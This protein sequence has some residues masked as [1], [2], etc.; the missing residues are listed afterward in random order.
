MSSAPVQRRRSAVPAYAGSH[1][2]GGAGVRLTPRRE[3]SGKTGRG[4]RQCE[5]P[6]GRPGGP[7]LGLAADRSLPGWQ[8]PRADMPRSPFRSG[9][10]MPVG[11]P[12]R[13]PGRIHGGRLHVDISCS[14]RR[15]GHATASACRSKG[16]GSGGSWRRRRRSWPRPTGR[17]SPHWRRDSA[18]SLPGRRGVCCAPGWRRRTGSAA[19][20]SRRPPGG[21]GGKVSGRP[22]AGVS[23]RR[24]PSPGC[25]CAAGSG[26]QG[27]P[28]GCCRSRRSRSGGGAGG[29][30]RCCAARRGAWRR[31]RVLRAPFRETANRAHGR[32]RRRRGRSRVGSVPPL[33]AGEL[34]GGAA[35]CQQPLAV[36]VHHV[37]ALPAP[38]LLD[39]RQ[40][41]AVRDHVLR[42][43]PRGGC[44]RRGGRPGR[45]RSRPASP[46]PCRC[47]GS[48][49]GRAP[50][51]AAPRQ[52]ERNS[53]PSATPLS[54]SHSATSAMVSGAT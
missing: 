26:A 1:G 33:H 2:W 7:C 49:S 20:S 50:R 32:C 10:R 52:S 12:T 4:E 25:G 5:G 28:A 54:S 16:T 41:D 39:R 43:R 21:S 6:G 18:P 23:G 35:P 3:G 36:A 51:P 38:G 44:A 9:L 42:P 22:P 30:A 46:G 19:G 11:E 40:P 8:D 53:R 13:S 47:A 24:L 48:G 45:P 27:C 34:R 14:I 37:G 31:A 17:G 15:P 29:R